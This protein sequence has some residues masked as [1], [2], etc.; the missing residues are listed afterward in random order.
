[1]ATLLQQAARQRKEKGLGFSAD[2]CLPA[3]DNAK[4]TSAACEWWK[5]KQQFDAKITSTWLEQPVQL[6]EYPF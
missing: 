5:G 4:E 2:L 3:P 1:M 6:Y